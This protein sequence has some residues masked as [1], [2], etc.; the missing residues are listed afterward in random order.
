MIIIIW[1]YS[2]E[3]SIVFNRA[4]TWQCHDICIAHNFGIQ[5]SLKRPEGGSRGAFSYYQKA[6]KTHFRENLM[7]TQIVVPSSI[8]VT[9]GQSIQDGGP[10]SE[11]GPLNKLP[12]QTSFN[13]LLEYELNPEKCER[14]VS[15]NRE[16]GCG[17]FY[18]AL[19][20][21][22]SR[23]FWID[24]KFGPNTSFNNNMNLQQKVEGIQ[25]PSYRS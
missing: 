22:E 16:G 1:G 5:V 2:G 23:L 8:A 21:K 3:D 7:V 17:K 25:Y 19:A 12:M 10:Y 18:V 14:V 13:G 15:Y 24:C 6:L 20:W 11:G 4:F 9:N